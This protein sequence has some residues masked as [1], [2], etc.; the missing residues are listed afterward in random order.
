MSSLCEKLYLLVDGELPEEEAGR[1]RS[2]LARCSTCA[3][4][5]QD[6]LE[7]ELLASDAFQGED[8]PC[9]DATRRH[10]AAEEQPSPRDAR[11]SG[12]M[13]APLH[14]TVVTAG[15][16]FPSTPERKAPA[17]PAPR[18]LWRR[19]P[20][21]GF[22]AMA[23]LAAVLYVLVPRGGPPAEL[24]LAEAPTRKI[25]ARLSFETLDRHRPYEPMRSAD[26][27]VQRVPLS[28]LSRLDEEKDAIAI[29]AAF[30]VRGDADQ[31]RGFLETAPPSPDRDNDLAVIAM[32]KGNLQEAL[33][34]LEQVLQVEP[35]H[36]QALW[37]Q[38]LVLRDLGRK[39]RAAAAFEQIA[40]RGEPGWS[41]EATRMARAL[42][43]Q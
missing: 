31:A 11:A 20:A 3:A 14:N 37:N 32:Q 12:P 5:F 24:W 15:T 28:E 16:L 13:E 8:D 19:K 23:T 25:E 2:H 22:A 42:R 21:R 6:A 9:G 29:A 1:V 33:R 27:V 38:A 43:E 10:S 36:P 39:E 7:M 4:R 35:Q 17:A 34:L 41:E 18:P 30:L 26:P 40:A